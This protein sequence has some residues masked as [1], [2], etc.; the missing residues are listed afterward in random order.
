M[1]ATLQGEGDGFDLLDGEC[2]PPLGLMS[3][4]VSV[5]YAQ[6]LIHASYA[7]RDGYLRVCL[8]R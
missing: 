7:G 5:G 8:I 2:R 1:G 4:V 6:I 3:E